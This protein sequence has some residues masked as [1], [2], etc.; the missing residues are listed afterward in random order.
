MEGDEQDVR[1]MCTSASLFIFKLAFEIMT[2]LNVD[3]AA[4]I[5]WMLVFL[6]LYGMSLIAAVVA[7][8]QKLRRRNVDVLFLCRHLAISLFFAC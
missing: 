5:H 4:G 2:C 1:E 8:R 6:P 3:Q 7:V